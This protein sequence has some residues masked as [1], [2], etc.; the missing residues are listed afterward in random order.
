[1]ED[2]ELKITLDVMNLN[3]PLFPLFIISL[4]FF[5]N[6]NAMAGKVY[7]WTDGEG[8]V[9]F[10]DMPPSDSTPVEVQEID[11][12]SYAGNDTDPDEYSIIN[13]LERMSERRRQNTEERLAIKRLQLEEQR[14]AQ[15]M[16][17]RRYDVIS[18]TPRYAPFTYS[19]VY[20]RPYNYY[21]RRNFHNLPG[22]H[23]PYPSTRAQ[24]GRFSTGQPQT[25][26]HYSKIG[27]RF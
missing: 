5:A 17:N 12:V 7:Q 25:N 16:E 26:R 27:I 20:S 19:Y 2:Y 15:E 11:L 1:M 14:L 8:V 18:S 24:Q 10:S 21:P 3:N 13:Q 22:Y 23:S 4:I 9:H 6:Q